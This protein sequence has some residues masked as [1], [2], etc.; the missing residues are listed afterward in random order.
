MH[1][2]PYLVT[3]GLDVAAFA[4]LDGLRERYFPADRNVV[5]AHVS[6]FHKL[7]GDEGDA[8]GAALEESAAASGPIALRFGGLKYT[9]GGVMAAVESPG[10]A[11]IHRRLSRHFDAWLTPQDRQPYRPHITIMNKAE[12][13]A[14]RRAYEELQIGW[15]AWE[16]VGESLR[17]WEYLGGPWRAVAAYPLAAGP[18]RTG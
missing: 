4:R 18:G 9:G 6:L 7:P 16:G 14:A 13:S 15:S 11:A 17:L 3:L 10:L 1:G 12:K 8:I 2:G 5:P